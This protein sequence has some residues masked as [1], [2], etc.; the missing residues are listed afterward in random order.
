MIEKIV[1]KRGII[2]NFIKETFFLHF[3]LSIWEDDFWW[4]RVENSTHPFFIPLISTTPINGKISFSILPLLHP[5]KLTIK[6]NRSGLDYYMKSKWILVWC[7]IQN[8]KEKKMNSMLL[9]VND[10]Q[11]CIFLAMKIC[12]KDFDIS[13]MHGRNYLVLLVRRVTWSSQVLCTNRKQ[14]CI[15]KKKKKWLNL[16]DHNCNT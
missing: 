5:T 1:I 12:K 7:F 3:F 11:S 10:S 15:K 2:K 13:S 16:W 6:H 14:L 4:A 9:D 8:K